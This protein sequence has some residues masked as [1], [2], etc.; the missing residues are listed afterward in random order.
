MIELDYMTTKT[1]AER[2]KISQRRVLAL[3]AQD[4]ISGLAR[5]ENIWLIPKNAQK[6]N[7]RRTTRRSRISLSSAKVKPFVKWAGGKGQ[8][9]EQIRQKY[10]AELGK[11]VKKYC[12]PFVG[13]GAVLFDVLSQYALEEVYVNDS[14][15]ELMNVYLTVQ[16][17]VEPLIEMLETMQQEY[18]ALSDEERR[19]YY[20]NMRERFN[21]LKQTTDGCVDVELAA[22]FVF[23]NRTCFN[24]LYR[25]NKHGCFNVPIGAYKNPLICDRENLLNAS[26]ALQGVIIKCGDYREAM[27]F[28]DNETFVY[29]DPPYR[30]LCASS[31]FTAYTEDGFDDKAQIDLAAFIQQLDSIGAKV[32]LSNSDPKNVN[33]EDDFFDELYANQKIHRITAVRA[34]NSKGASRGK[35]S[36]LLITN[37]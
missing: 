21:R 17:A 1:A 8:L 23:L 10:P 29:I 16:K 4:R 3:C 7:D 19:V 37:Y 5:V 22:L 25:V 20:G 9:L 35:V 28:I 6:P 34:I 26:K 18:R 36:E 11:T 31:S 27:G 24:G 13:G 2:W 15:V 33:T 32:L 12:E 30:P 14:N